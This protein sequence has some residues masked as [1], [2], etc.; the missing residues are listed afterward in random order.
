MKQNVR[1]ALGFFW[2][3]FKIGWYTFGGGWSIVAQMQT[4]YVEK[5]H[6]MEPEELLDIISVGR[7]LPGT[8]AGNVAYLFGYHQCGVIGGVL[9]V[10]GICTPPVLILTVITFCYNTFRDNV[11][12]AKAM[13]GVRCVVVPIII[14]AVSKL[15]KGSFSM[16]ICYALCLTSMLLSYCLG[17]SS[18]VLVLAGLVIGL[19]LHMFMKQGRKNTTKA[20]KEGK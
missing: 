11:W 20:F 14:S 15:L 4:D 16:K 19:L 12:V 18:I 2:Y 6:V 8:M 9:S 13:V 5:K 7:S 3:F 17:T 10:L 1:K